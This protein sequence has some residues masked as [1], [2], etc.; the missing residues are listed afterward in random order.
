MELIIWAAGATVLGLFLGYLG[1]LHSKIA[2]S[3]FTVCITAFVYGSNFMLSLLGVEREASEISAGVRLLSWSPSCPF[4]R[5]LK[6]WVIYRPIF[7]SR[8]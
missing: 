8:L 5:L 1:Y 2:Y 4:E 6:I 3:I 7:G